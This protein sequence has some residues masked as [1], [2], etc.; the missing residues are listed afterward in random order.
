MR[1]IYIC[2]LNLKHPF[3]FAA[4][5]SQNKFVVPEGVSVEQGSDLLGNRMFLVRGMGPVRGEKQKRGRSLHDVQ[6]WWG[7]AHACHVTA[8]IHVCRCLR[9]FFWSGINVALD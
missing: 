6:S 4:R 3:S 9:L 2:W 1:I 7:L 8:L 5:L